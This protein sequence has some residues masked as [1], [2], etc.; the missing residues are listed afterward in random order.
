M[1]GCENRQK[2]AWVQLSLHPRI[3]N[4]CGRGARAEMALYPLDG[5][6][7]FGGNLAWLREVISRG[8]PTR[9]G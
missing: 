9:K 4:H 5:G 2:G 7:V 1:E 8:P 6:T 3:Y